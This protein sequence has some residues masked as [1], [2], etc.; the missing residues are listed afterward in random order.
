MSVTF[1]KFDRKVDYNSVPKDNAMT[2]FAQNAIIVAVMSTFFH[3][4]I[5]LAVVA[6][7]GLA[8]CILPGIREY[9]FAHKGTT[10]LG[11][12]ILLTVITGIYYKNYIG[13]LISVLVAFMIVIHLVARSVATKPFF[14][15]MFDVL[16]VGGCLSTVVCIIEK[17]A[18]RN[19]PD[20]RC[21]CFSVNPNCYGV[22]ILVVILICAYKA[23]VV[24]KKVYRYYVCAVFNAVS[25]YLCGSMMLW[26]IAFIGIL[27]L[28]LLN[29]KYKLLAVFLGIASAGVIAILVMPQ[30]IPRL[31]EL[32]ATIENRVLIWDFA[33]EQIKEA[34]VFGKGFATYN[35]M[36]N[37]LK[38][39]RPEIYP[40]M[41][42]HNLII[43]GVLS[44]GVV[45]MAFLGLFFASFIKSAFQCREGLKARNK[46]Y[47]MITFVCAL[48]VAVAVHGLLD[49][50]MIWIQSGLMIMLIGSGL[51]VCENELKASVLEEKISNNPKV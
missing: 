19:M 13:A 41:L 18:N 46:S 22:A 48:A 39:V 35:F 14:E 12:F 24:E 25:I 37:A 2:R 47:V 3:A 45:G 21:Q 6:L 10:W 51:G 36:F 4:V 27:T 15:K 30:L 28:L 44:Y 42:S 43:D 50:A 7:T 1:R 8:F 33:I 29:H 49:T 34:P 17:I 9:I 32:T 16:C 23:I 11:A 38:E 20:Y 26:V 40:A 5:G 31:H